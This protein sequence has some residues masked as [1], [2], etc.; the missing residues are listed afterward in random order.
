MSALFV[1]VT[2][3]AVNIPEV[4]LPV[5]PDDA[6]RRCCCAVIALLTAVVIDDLNCLLHAPVGAVED[7]VAGGSTAVTDVGRHSTAG[8]V[9]IGFILVEIDTL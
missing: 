5:E 4:V 2:A 7:R 6:D 1:A 3:T 8:Q 9:Q